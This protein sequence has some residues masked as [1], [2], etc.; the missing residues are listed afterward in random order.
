[1]IFPNMFLLRFL[2]DMFVFILAVFSLSRWRSRKW[3]L[4]SLW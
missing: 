1:M 4:A 3:R 2:A